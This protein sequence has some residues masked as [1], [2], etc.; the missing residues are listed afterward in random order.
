MKSREYLNSFSKFK[1]DGGFRPGLHRVEAALEKLGNP[2]KELQVIHVA[3]TNGKGSTSA[4]MASILNEAGYR[5]GFYSSPHLQDFSER[6]RLNGVPIS[7]ND[8]DFVTEKIKPVMEEIARDPELG[9]PSFFEVVTVLAFV[10]FAYKKVDVL[11]LEVGLGGRLDATNVVYPLASVITS[12]GLDHT[13][14]LGTTLSEIA[15]EK[16]GIIKHNIPVITG[17]TK[18]EAFQVIFEQAKARDA[19]LYSPIN[20]ANWERL[21]ADLR[22]QTLNLTLDDNQFSELKLGLLGEHQI[23][24]AVVA[25]KTLDIL[26]KYFTAL[27]EQVIRNGLF[28]VSWPG[29]LELIRENPPVLLDGAHNLEGIIALAS[30]LARV[31]KNYNNLYIVMSILKDKNI[32]AMIAK[33][34][35]LTTQIIFTQNHNLRASSAEQVKQIL[36]D[37]AINIEIIPDFETA[38]NTVLAKAKNDDLVCI[39][40]SLYT[41]AEARDIFTTMKMKN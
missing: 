30:F 11:I 8:L 34:V 17:V 25:L 23:R 26:K 40:G 14:Y 32:K 35:P 18:P 37:Q 6:F 4:M 9:R 5:V 29:R 16:A 31:K 33:M 24:N 39:T 12:I 1:T 36:A 10:Y 7:E 21:D 22:H 27:D 15:F 20:Q 13:E 28:K 38:I 2:E 3:G 19:D 41:I